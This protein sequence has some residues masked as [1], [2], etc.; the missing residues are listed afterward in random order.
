MTF[1]KE[2][3]ICR[4]RTNI[5][6]KT[7]FYPCA[8]VSRFSQRFKE[9]AVSESVSLFPNTLIILTYCLFPNMQ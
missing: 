5:V 9:T 4:T 6:V 7:S 8:T 3:I 1:N 2:F